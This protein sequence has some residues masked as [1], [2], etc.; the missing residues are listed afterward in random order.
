MRLRVFLSA[1]LVCLC[2]ALAP[3][4]FA[5]PQTASSEVVVDGKVCDVAG[6][7]ITG[8]KVQ[9][10]TASGAVAA[11]GFTDSSGS[12]RLRMAREEYSFTLNI[13]P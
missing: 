1:L 4:A 12:Y 8:A 7:P 6:A 5:V 10:E 13:Q 9:L 11:S 3:R 2:G